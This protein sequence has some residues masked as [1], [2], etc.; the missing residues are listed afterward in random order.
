VKDASPLVLTST[1]LLPDKSSFLRKGDKLFKETGIAICDSNFLQIFS[2]PLLKGDAGTA[3][4]E[5]NSIVITRAFE[6]KYFD[7]GSG[8]GKT[9]VSGNTSL[10]VTGVIDKVPERSHFH[11]DAFVSMTTYT[12]I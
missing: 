6:K 12:F 7:N 2:I 1:R 5:P 8:L 11:Y 10:K 4:V 3:L 9:L